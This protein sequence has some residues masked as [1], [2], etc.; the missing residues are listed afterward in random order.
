MTNKPI[1]LD[2]GCGANKRNASWTGMDKSPDVNPDIVWDARDI[3]W[4]FR[5]ESVDVIRSGHFLEHL[6]GEELIPIM[7]EQWRILKWCD[8]DKVGYVWHDVPRAGCLSAEQDPTHKN[9]LVETS[10]QFFCGEYI[11]EYNLDYGIKCAFWM[12]P[13]HPR[14]WVPHNR[15]ADQCTMITF[16]MAKMRE[17]F[18]KFKT[19]F[20]L[21]KAF[22]PYRVGSYNDTIPK[23]LYPDF[24]RNE[25]WQTPHNIQFSGKAKMLAKRA[26]NRELEK[27]VKIKVDASKRYGDDPAPLGLKGLFADINRKHKRAK[28]YMWEGIRDT[29]ENIEDTLSDMAVY[30]ILGLMELDERR[31][32]GR[33]DS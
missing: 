28:R 14:V 19:K 20:P 6:S 15:T 26:V 3:P 13:K 8:G 16:G 7:N 10:M 11:V 24:W 31:K 17:H 23:V 29:S 33:A 21:N 1:L 2:I 25:H 12:L 4:P 30:A 9:N 18:D 5:D 27:I 32:D 22:A